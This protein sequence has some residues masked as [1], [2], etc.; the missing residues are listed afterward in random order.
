MTPICRFPAATLFS[1]MEKSIGVTGGAEQAEVGNILWICYNDKYRY[2]SLTI[3][4]YYNQKL[5]MD[6]TIIVPML[7]AYLFTLA[8]QFNWKDS[9][10]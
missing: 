6:V 2:I 3:L 5:E 1:S 7:K 8:M 9:L 4:S 10:I